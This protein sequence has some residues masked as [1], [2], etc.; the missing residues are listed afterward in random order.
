MI[1]LFP[2]LNI[3]EILIVLG[4]FIY[5]LGVLFQFDWHL[6]K[7]EIKDLYEHFTCFYG[8]DK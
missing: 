6:F 2:M 7:R 5:S 3:G 8:L 4:K 1:I